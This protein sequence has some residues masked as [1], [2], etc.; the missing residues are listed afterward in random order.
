WHPSGPLGQ[1]E[2]L[3][4]AALRQALGAHARR[5]RMVVLCACSGADP[6]PPGSQLGSAAQA[7]HQLGIPAVVAFRF[8]ISKHGSL[9]LTET[10]YDELLGGTGSLQQA[11]GAARG[12]LAQE[13]G[14]LD[15]ASLQLYARAE[16]GT[17]L[18]PFVL[19]PFRGLLAF[20]S[21]HRRFFF[22]REALQQVV[23]ER[24]Q[25]SVRGTLPRFQV[26]AGASG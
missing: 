6:G 17:D 21:H 22:G 18:R 3:D 26:V 25:Q 7:L 11:L 19:R 23:L 15:W 24:I 16:D 13:S 2:V 1:L 5:I 10:L 14:S 9:R 8:P 12:R 4:A 20:E